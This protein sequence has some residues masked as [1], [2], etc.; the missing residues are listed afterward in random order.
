MPGLPRRLAENACLCACE[1]KEVHPREIYFCNN[2]R[3]SFA[4]RDSRASTYQIPQH[5][6]VG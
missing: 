1:S 5:H 4:R 2:C 3:N 6:D